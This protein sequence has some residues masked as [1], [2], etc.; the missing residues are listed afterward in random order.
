MEIVIKLPKNT[1]KMFV[2]AHVHN[3]F[4]DYDISVMKEVG[5][6]SQAAMVKAI[7]ANQ[8]MVEDKI[9]KAFKKNL[10]LNE[11]LEDIIFEINLKIVNDAR[12]KA[13]KA[14]NV[15]REREKAKKQAQIEKENAARE[16]TRTK[17]NIQVMLKTLEEAGYTVI[18]KK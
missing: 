10:N 3:L 18:K 16:E 8:S 17:N 1:A 9:A 2:E 13:D 15:L 11:I 14:E 12:R 7:M 4:E 6:S 5:Y